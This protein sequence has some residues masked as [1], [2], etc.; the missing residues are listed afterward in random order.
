MWTARVLA[1][2]LVLRA[3]RRRKHKALLRLLAFA[4]RDARFAFHFLQ[5]GAACTIVRAYRASLRERGWQS[6]SH[7]RFLNRCATK[8]QALTRGYFGRLYARWYKETLAAA[9]R[10]MQRV[11]RGKLGRRIWRQLVTE[12]KQRLRDQEEEDRAARVSRKLSSQYGLDAYEKDCKHARVLQSWYQTMKNRQLFKQAGELRAKALELRGTEKLALVVKMSTE[13]V[14]FQ[15]R[16]W[17]DCMEQKEALREMEEDECIAM[18]KEIAELKKACRAA[19]VA[20]SQAAAEHNVVLQHKSDFVRAKKQLARATDQ[21]KTR[22][23]PFAVQAKKLTKQSAR[24]HV[25][26]K[27]LQH[28]LQSVN[29]SIAAL[30][31]H[32]HEVLPYEP[33][34]LQSDV[35]YL[36]TLLE[37]PNGRPSIVA[38][39][40]G[41]GGVASEE[42]A[43][44]SG[45]DFEAVN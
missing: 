36:L 5:F 2:S 34:L 6:P 37:L 42:A 20:T 16:V 24:V 17:R 15:S 23:K 22:I 4:D 25:V 12:R 45:V 33:L 1:F 3:D 7:I 8:I 41:A 19:H 39:E 30:H 14:V 28:E 31:R 13:S 29:K 35:A 40:V 26:N 44:S 10:V 27:Q 9:V 21:V 32:L 38:D 11:W 43:T 18:E